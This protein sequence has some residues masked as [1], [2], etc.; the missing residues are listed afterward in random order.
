[1]DWN[2]KEIQSMIEELNP[3]LKHK[4]VIHDANWAALQREQ[5]TNIR[6]DMTRCVK[7]RSP[8]LLQHQNHYSFTYR[9]FDGAHWHTELC[10]VDLQQPKAGLTPSQYELRDNINTIMALKDIPRFQW[11]T[12]ETQKTF[13]F[14]SRYQLL[15]Y[16]NHWACCID[17]A[18]YLESNRRQQ[19]YK[20]Y[21]EITFS[22]KNKPVFTI[23]STKAIL[24][25]LLAK[26]Q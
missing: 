5:G 13:A 22:T 4:P 11:L 19:K 24:D 12:P 10:A 1:M 16:H 14:D 3:E 7:T 6:Y 26:K 9:R 20:D 21:V 18:V 8:T 15:R 23:D 17:N 2:S 25:K